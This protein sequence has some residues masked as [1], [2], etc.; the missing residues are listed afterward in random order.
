MKR[1][2]AL[3]VLIVSF[4]TV[5]AKA[6]D[7]QAFMSS[8]SLAN[9]S[10]NMQ[11]TGNTAPVVRPA[12]YKSPKTALFLSAAVPGA[13][14]IYEGS[15]LKAAG[16]VAVEAVGWTVWAVYSTKGKDIR[17]EFRSYADVHWIESDYWDWIAAQSG[18]ERSDM[19]A[20]R[21]WE[22][23]A[24]SHGL[25]QQK[26]QQYYEMIGKYDQFNAGW[27]D[28]S[29]SYLDEGWDTSQRSKR[30]LYYEDRRDASNQA[31]KKGSMGIT[32][33]MLNHI[34]SAIEG[35]FSASRHNKKLTQTSL[36]FEPKNVG[37][38]PV[39]ALTMRIKW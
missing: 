13:G 29:T 28:A 9:Q 19:A 25:N 1:S 2:I 8:S 38:Q 32:V 35:A 5:E 6:T 16:F 37:G 30:R 20:L 22:H 15:L 24:F 31:F 27:D 18:K 7:W 17:T 3:F 26:D 11:E 23:E 21:Q 4:I 10:V 39:T 12:G 36:R 33:V 14:Q 34:F